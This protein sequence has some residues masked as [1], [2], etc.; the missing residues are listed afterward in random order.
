[1]PHD[2]G[3]TLLET[4]ITLTLIALFA[5]LSFPFLQHLSTTSHDQL[6]QSQL[7][8]AIDIAHH[9]ARNQGL[10]LVLCPTVDR[11]TCTQEIKKAF[12]LFIDEKEQGSVLSQDHIIAILPI[13]L[14]RGRLYWRAYPRYRQYLLFLPNGL[15][16]SDNSTFWFCAQNETQ[17]RWALMLSQ[18]GRTRILTPNQQGIINDS[19]Q[20]P[21]RCEE[22][23]QQSST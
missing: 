5:T 17:P 21:L 13:N 11:L 15:Q 9:E 23:H 6:T 4:L 12:L 22:T 8:N 20:K 1:M 14:H 7:L 10:P 19:H 3:F 18:S 2:N 16:H